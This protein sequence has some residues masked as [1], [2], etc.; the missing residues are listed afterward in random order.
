MYFGAS[1]RKSTFGDNET[2]EEDLVLSLQ[3]GAGNY[4]LHVIARHRSRRRPDNHCADACKPPHPT[5]LFKG[6]T[7][8]VEPSDTAHAQCSS[9]LIYSQQRLS[10][11]RPLHPPLHTPTSPPSPPAVDAATSINIPTRCRGLL[12]FAP[13]NKHN[14]WNSGLPRSDNAVG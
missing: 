14:D 4:Q 12:N 9:S 5:A 11:P 2:K 6:F 10:I 1:Q 8:R 3:A 7:L 13:T